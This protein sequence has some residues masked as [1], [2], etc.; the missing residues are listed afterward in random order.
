MQSVFQKERRE[1]LERMNSRN[2]NDLGII[3]AHKVVEKPVAEEKDTDNKKKVNYFP[4]GQGDEVVFEG[5]AMF[6]VGHYII[7]AHCSCVSPLL[8]GE[9]GVRLIFR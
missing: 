4:R 3:I 1:I 9:G 7:V 6:I 5:K 8:S 2:T